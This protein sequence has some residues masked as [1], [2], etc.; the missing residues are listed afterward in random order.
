MIGMMALVAAILSFMALITGLLSI[1]EHISAKECGKEGPG[2]FQ[3]LMLLVGSSYA[4]LLI[5][6]LVRMLLMVC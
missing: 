6:M 1:W 3:I 2:I 5:I 4:A